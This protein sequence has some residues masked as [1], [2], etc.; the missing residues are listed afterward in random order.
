[1]ISFNPRFSCV[2]FIMITVFLIFVEPCQSKSQKLELYDT[3]L[4][5]VNPSLR[6]NVLRLSFSYLNREEDEK[7]YWKSGSVDCTCEVYPIDSRYEKLSKD[8]IVIKRQFFNES[9]DA[10]FLDVP[11]SFSKKYD[12]GFVE[13]TMQIGWKNLKA[14]EKFWVY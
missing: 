1:M 8:P 9:K 13:C 5:Y 7:I 6:N 3:D 2:I 10:M 4:V 12:R 14:E 11:D